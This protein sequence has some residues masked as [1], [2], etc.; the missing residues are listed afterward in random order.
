MR[1][2]PRSFRF[3]TAIAVAAAVAVPLVLRAQD[4]REGGITV[5][6]NP[7][8]K[9]HALTIDRDVPDLRAFGLDR[10]VSSFRFPPGQ[11]WEV[12]TGRD[13]TGRCRV[14]TETVSDLRHSDWNDDIMSIR[15]VPGRPQ[16]FAG[17]PPGSL[18]L[19]AGTDFSGRRIVLTG[20][21]PDFRRF[22][23]ND[24]ALSLRAVSGEA[25]EVCYNIDFDD[26]RVVD[27]EL[28]NLA[29]FN[30]TGISSARPRGRDWGLRPASSI[31][32]YSGREFSGDFRVLSGSNPDLNRSH[33]NDRAESLR[34]PRGQSWEVC[35]NAGFDD[36]RVVDRDIPDLAAMGLNRNISSVRPHVIR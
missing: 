25:W 4:G 22:N 18:E 8:F 6:E 19:Y 34:V 11:S 2:A 32:L 5:Y 31:E 26:C 10:Q 36:C 16:G 13:F 27:G 14:F 35:I 15:R 21:A 33:F 9:G 28:P 29:R 1:L 30:L 17:V 7:D 3:I 20:P 24:R 12:C 23:F